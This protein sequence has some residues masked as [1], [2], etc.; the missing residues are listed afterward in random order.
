MYYLRTKP[1]ADAIKFTV[2]KKKVT[3]SS[4]TNGVQEKGDD[5]VDVD[6]LNDEFANKMICSLKNKEDCLMCGS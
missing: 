6:D 3:K 4:Q 2:D 1:A 5:E